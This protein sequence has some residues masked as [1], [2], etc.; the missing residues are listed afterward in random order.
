MKVLYWTELF[1]PHI[2]GIEVLATRF[3]PAMQGRGYEFAVVTSPHNLDLPEKDQYGDIPVYRFPFRTALSTPNLNQLIA[4]QRQVAKL[5]QTFKPDLVHVNFSGPSP[6][7]HLRT[8]TV[9][10]A[11]TLITM[12][13]LPAHTSG[14]NSLLVK[15]HR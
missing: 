14:H 9:H 13:I 6:L 11:P 1:W 10:P 12:H 3:L 15:C 2:G 4:V 7:L 8:T 5:K